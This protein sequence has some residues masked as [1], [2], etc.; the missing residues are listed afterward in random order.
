[1]NERK[2]GVILSYFN[3]ILQVLIGFIYVPIL[4]KYLGQSEYGLYQLMGS[5]IAYF[6]IMDFGLTAS[7]IR[8]YIKYKTNGEIKR[9]ENFLAITQRIYFFVCVLVLI[10]GSIVYN[11]L[12]DMFANSL[13]TNEL[14][15]AKNI[16][17]LLV[18]N[19]IITF[20]GMIY[21]SVIIANEKFLFF[22]IVEALQLIAQPIMV[23]LIIQFSPTAL[24]MVIVITVLNV[25]ITMIRV[26][27]CYN[28]LNLKI[29]YYNWDKDAISEMKK[30]SISVF[31]V[32][33]IDQIFWKSNQIILGIIS[34][35][36][37]V[38][39]YSIASLIYMNYMAL[40]T[41]ITGIYSPKIMKMVS[42]NVNIKNLSKEFLRIGRLQYYILALILSGFF[43][44][45]KE[46]IM[47][48]CNYN[49][50]NAYYITLIIIT[51]F[52]IDLIQNI[53]TIM[54]KAKNIYD[55]RAKI[56]FIVG[57]IN[58][59]LSIPLAKIY[60]EIGCAVA[61][62]FSILVSNIIMN[63][64]FKRV[65]K[66]DIIL[67]WKQILEITLSVFVCII[68]GI[69]LN[70]IFYESN[71]VIFIVK[72]ILFSIIYFMIM[73]KLSFNYDERQLFS[74]LK[75]KIKVY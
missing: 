73:W 47:I 58:I 21:R 19:I 41:A 37:A 49:F 22:K 6:S 46:F 43:V 24:A 25:I 72:L 2:I 29:N 50:I 28:R 59:C 63:V 33:I 38:A 20:L 52:T 53:A 13:T 39:I 62:G 60:G 10:I 66:L 27:Y 30:L 40:S 32:A 75:N 48:W 8:G 35:V 67:F 26:Y 54:M 68:I 16:F 45:G 61:C 18:F 57:I 31:V 70:Y 64:Y 69:F 14:L 7:T 12:D 5:I 17:I 9:T 51:P 11:Y 42:E 71:I 1:M 34:G 55:F 74:K 23:I 15:E 3:I 44:F 56:Y 65:L 36:N 4:L